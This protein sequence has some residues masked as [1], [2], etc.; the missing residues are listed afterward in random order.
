MY[1]LFRCKRRKG[2]AEEK[3]EE[4][5]GPKRILWPKCLMRMDNYRINK[6][7]LFKRKES[8]L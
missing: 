8:E 2:N 4:E 3:K 1:P 5:I 6:E 7:R